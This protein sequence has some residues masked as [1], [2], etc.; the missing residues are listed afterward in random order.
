MW[1]V[2]M[3]SVLVACSPLTL[4]PVEDRAVVV[5]DLGN[6]DIPTPNDVARD[7]KGGTLSL[8]IEEDQSPAEVAFRTTLNRQDGWSSASSIQLTFSEPLD[9]ES[10]SEETLEIWHWGDLPEPVE[11]LERVLSEDGLHVE[12]AAPKTGFVHGDTYVVIA[13][14]GE[15]AL[16]AASG[17]PITADASFAYVRSESSL[18]GHDRAVPGAD[19]EQREETLQRLEEIRLSL[20]P[21]VQDAVR[22]GIPR[23]EIAALWSFTVTSRPEIA[24]D[25]DSQR[26]PV[27]IDLLID[28]STGLVSLPPSEDDDELVAD[29][30]LVLSTY[31]GA[32]VSGAITFDTTAPLDPSTIGE[33]NVQLWLLGPNSVQVPARV[34]IWSEDGPCQGGETDCVHVVL[35][36]DVIPLMP[37]ADYALVV[38]EGPAGID[39]MP[40]LAMAPG[41]LLANPDPLLDE[42][43]ESTISSV[44]RGDAER[45][46]PVRATVDGLLDRLFGEERAGLVAA[47]PFRTLDAEA[48]L[49][50]MVSLAELLG[51]DPEPVVTDRLDPVTL[52]GDDGLGLLFPPPLN[53]AWAAYT[54]RL[55]GV[56]EVVTGTIRSPQHLHPVTRRWTEPAVTDEIA[57]VATVPEGVPDD[58]PVPVV[59][60]GHAVVTD[61][62]WVMTI[63]G[64]LAKKGFATISIDFPYHGERTYCLDSSLVA[65]PNF[66]PDVL[67]DL[68]DQ[69]DPLLRASPCVSGEDATCSPTGECLGPDGQ[70][71][72]FYA[73]PFIDIRPAAGAAMLDVG[74]LPHVPDHFRQALVDLGALRWSLQAGDWES[75]LGQAIR[76]DSFLYAG[77]SLGGIIGAV[78]VPVEPRVMRAVLNVPGADLVDLFQDSTFF[79]PQMAEY[80]ASREV[81]PG[82]YEEL[83]LLNTARWLVD[84]VDPHSV[85]H[86]WAEHGTEGLIQMDRVDENS[87]D[88]VIPNATTDILA[89]VSGLPVMEYPSILHGDLVIPLLGDA[90]L[91]DLADFLAEGP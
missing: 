28:Q 10:L 52:L 60:F 73:F 84:A 72:D 35:T 16:T 77:Q 83:R 40:L 9:P 33:E 63:A 39:G 89:E 91:E 70:P 88:I 86:L 26:M 5:Y 62:R 1:G 8:P 59:I 64:E 13:R 58:E 30:K 38:S 55:D 6:S 54:Y 81:V 74:D 53:P 23:E 34:Q 48:D 57:F 18:D 29:A 49:T 56:A 27:P 25:A 36:P 79:G 20:Q 2:L 37:G 87:G 7:A 75:A 45:L 51:T 44:G 3:W 50:E 42:L 80:L 22:R 11:G 85:G 4:D 47:W 82:S 61:R 90:M 46:E 66:L 69:Q 67:K 78:Y 21:F 15:G 76:T 12:V 19:R 14:G 17:V 31:N 68:L 32:S 65:V 41:Q 71:E 24:M 43:G